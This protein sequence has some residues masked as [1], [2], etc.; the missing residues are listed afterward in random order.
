MI[1]FSMQFPADF[2]WGT[3]TAAHQVEGANSNNNWY[4]WES[5]LKHIHRN[6]RAGIACDWWAGQRYLEDF[7]R[8]ANELH[9]NAHRMSVEWSRIEPEPGRFDLDALDFYAKMIGALRERHLEPMVTLH[10]FTNPLWMEKDGGWTNPRNIEYF[11]RFVKRTTAALGDQ[12]KFW[13]TINEPMVYATQGYLLGKFPPGK[14]SMGQTT[15]VIENMLRAHAAAYHAIKERWPDAQVGFAKHQISLK[16]RFPQ[17]INL[18][19]VRTVR[20]FF[21]EAFIEA[22]MSGTL[23]LPMRKV[24]IPEARDTLD[25]IG[26][27]YYYRFLAAYNLLYPHKLFIE[28][29]KPRDGIR[30]PGDVGEIWPEGLAEHIRWL[31]QTTG[32]PLYVTENGVADSDDALRPLHM[33]RSLRSV[34]QAINHNYLVK[35]YFWWTL[36]DNFEWAEGYD[37]RFHFGLYEC[38]HE[39]Q[40]RTKR[41]S[42]DLYGEIC[43]TNSITM[44][45]ARR[46]I[47]DKAEELFPS[48]NV[49]AEVKLPARG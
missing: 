38:N 1:D 44:D 35:G 39:T 45:M 11:V 16:T 22:I 36:V 14:H 47:P 40:E 27:N 7:D 48:V 12:V 42:A 2:L 46:Y 23:R 37:P 43:S 49:K 19:A 8:A 4:A 10:H 20:H 6:Q 28:Q 24:E 26:L 21:N 29:S 25:W 33:M 30:G 13:C 32:K 15:L 34:W 18:P 5:E 31:C 41:P 3:A 9:N 17:W